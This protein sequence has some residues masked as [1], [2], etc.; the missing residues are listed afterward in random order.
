M[1]VAVGSGIFRTP[2]DVAAALHD[3]LWIIVAWLVGGLVALMQCLVTAELATR[4]PQD[5]GEYVF[6]KKAYGEFAAFFFGWAYTIFILG[7]GTALIAAALGDF[8]CEL[9]HIDGRWSGWIAA[10]SIALV[11]GVNMAGLRIGAGMQNVLTVLKL[12]ALAGV[13]VAGFAFAVDPAFAPATQAEG[14]SQQDLAG[15]SA[16]AGFAAPTRASG[17]WD[18]WRTLAGGIPATSVLLAALLNVLWSYDGVADSAKLAEEIR[19]VRRA[20]PFGL[21]AGSLTLTALYLLVN[22]ALLRVV[23]A[24]EMAELTFVPGEAMARLFGAPGR[25]AVLAVATVVCLGALAAT[26]LAPVRVTFALARDRLAPAILG[27]MTNAQAPAAALAVVAL[28]GIVLALNR[29]FSQALQIYYFA[30][31]LLFGLTYAS[32]IVLRRREPDPGPQVFRAPAGVA[33]AWVLIVIQV[34]IAWHTAAGRPMDVLYSC[35]LFAVLGGLYFLRTCTMSRTA[36]L[37][38]DQGPRK[39]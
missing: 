3:P 18:V 26:L 8:A 30:S 28:L 4:V 24:E 22:L 12:A 39:D 16:A 2:G 32:L 19:D 35:L 23:P 5:G 37:V 17:E 34:L 6:L 14:A 38:R 33:Q 10:G 36:P 13:I 29:S 31:A 9:V 15:A 21:V 1:G 20:V 25:A 11:A 7:G 27:R